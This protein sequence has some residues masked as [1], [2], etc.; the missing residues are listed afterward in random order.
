MLRCNRYL[1][2][3]K[4]KKTRQQKDYDRKETKMSILRNYRN[5]RRYRNAVN[6]LS[7]LTNRELDDIG[8]SRAEIPL[9][10]RKGV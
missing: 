4:I 1:S 3:V 8:I 10:V 2:A 7:R 9:V 5:W 6:E